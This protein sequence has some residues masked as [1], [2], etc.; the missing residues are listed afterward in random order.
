MHRMAGPVVYFEAVSGVVIVAAAW[1]LGPAGCVGMA[2][3][4]PRV[5]IPAL[6]KLHQLLMEHGFKRSSRLS[7][8]RSKMS[9]L[10][11]P[12]LPFTAPRQLSM[13]LDSVRLRG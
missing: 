13:T 9:N 1:T 8:R 4:A 11:A 6:I 10:P 5:A 3:G 2:L 7:S 12:A